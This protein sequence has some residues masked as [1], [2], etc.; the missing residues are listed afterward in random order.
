MES[1]KK[2]LMLLPLLV[3]LWLDGTASQ[4]GDPE[5]SHEWAGGAWY[6]DPPGLS[7]ENRDFTWRWKP[8]RIPPY[9]FARIDDGDAVSLA[10]FHGKVVLVNVWATWCPPCVAEMP[11]L[12]NLQMLRGGEDFAVV[13]LSVD[14]QG[15]SVVTAFLK[16]H[17]L[18]NLVPYIGKGRETFD[19]FGMSELPTTFLLGR[20]GSVW[21]V[22]AGPAE[23]DGATA[24]KLIDYAI[25]LQPGP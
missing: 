3:L 24:L 9:E 7:G 23:W 6:G 17:G 15:P 20:D 21:G 1:P 16:K 10:D 8:T 5:S 18:K 25:G 12:D 14:S 2:F 19:H 11:A 22:I 13:A 4:A